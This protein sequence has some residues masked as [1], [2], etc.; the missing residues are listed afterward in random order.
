MNTKNNST[1]VPGTSIYSFTSDWLSRRFTLDQMIEK[2][3]ELNVGP[4]IEMVGFQ[5]IRGF[6]AISDEFA[7]HFRALVERLGLQPTALGGN[8]DLGRYPGRL[9]TMDEM[10]TTVE[11]QIEAARKLGFPVLRIQFVGNEVLEKLLPAA[12][13][14]QVQ[15]ACELHAPMTP[16][17][18]AV[19]ELRE[20]CD[21]TGSPYLGLVLDFSCSMTSPPERYWSQVR[22]SGAPEPLIA[23]AQEIWHRDASI[24]EKFAAL[25][26]AA[27]HYNA[28]P[29]L[30]GT[31]N[32]VMTMFGHMP[33]SAWR[34]VLP[35]SRH[36]HGKFYHVD[37][38]GNEP[39]IP[40]P[41]II[42][43]LKASGF[44]GSISAEWEG[45]AFNAQ[46]GVA[47]GEVQRWHAM[48]RRLLAA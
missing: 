25:A 33:V 23:A 24:P 27:Q 13:Q 17:H 37:E 31:L 39:A 38:H 44:R 19:V 41:Q 9:M 46:E 11:A 15:I 35:Y 3:A 32:M 21:R 34:E 22:H 8:I 43:L 1:I 14:A 30:T 2:V 18:P 7:A 5:S 29:G 28:P 45:H 47:F 20:L 16:A 26:Q 36:I 48:V 40:Y 6:P 12:E 42:A 10:I 4:G